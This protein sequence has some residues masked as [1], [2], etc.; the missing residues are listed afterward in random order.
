MLEDEGCRRPQGAVA[1][2]CATQRHPRTRDG[3]RRHPDRWQYLTAACAAGT[4]AQ[5]LRDRGPV[6][7]HAA[8]GRH[9]QPPGERQGGGW[10]PSARM[11]VDAQVVMQAGPGADLSLTTLVHP[12]LAVRQPSCRLKRRSCMPHMPHAQP[13]SAAEGAQSPAAA[14]EGACQPQVLI[15]DVMDTIVVDPFY[16]VRVAC[17]HVVSHCMSCARRPL[18]AQAAS[19]TVPRV[20]STPHPLAAPN[21]WHIRPARA[22]GHAP[23]LRHDLPRAAGGKAPDRLARL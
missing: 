15:L 12:V 11:P 18:L 7:Q 14:A 5:R 22:A 8:A 23:L 19:L 21:L 4:H 6:C 17:R 9:A 20:H 16:K 2:S 13:G 3:C 10:R 1:L